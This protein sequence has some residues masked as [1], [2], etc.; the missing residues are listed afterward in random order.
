VCYESRKEA[1]NYYTR[2]FGG[3]NWTSEIWFNFSIDTLLVICDFLGRDGA[4]VR[5]LEKA[6]GLENIR[7]LAVCAGLSWGQPKR[8]NSPGGK[9]ED[10]NTITFTDHNEELQSRGCLEIKIGHSFVLED[11]IINVLEEWKDARENRQILYGDVVNAA[12]GN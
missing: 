5:F 6:V 1:S 12:G 3:E 9:W 8:L 10:L 7:F 4:I 2:T 11:S